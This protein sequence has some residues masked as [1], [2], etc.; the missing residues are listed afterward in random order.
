[1][2]KKARILMFAVFAA[3]LLSAVFAAGCAQ[4][5]PPAE[6]LNYDMS[7]AKWN[8]TTPFVYDGEEKSVTI[9]GLPD[10]VTVKEYENNSAVN[11]GTYTASATFD[12]DE[13]RYNTP[14]IAPCE[15]VIE[16]AEITGLS[17]ESKTVDY[18]GEKYSLTVT[19]DLPAGT[20]VRYTYNGTVADGVTEVDNY[21]VKVTVSGANYITWE[22]VAEL[23]IRQPLT[24][25]NMA[26]TVIG[27]F[28]TVPDFMSFLPEIYG[29]EN[30]LLSAPLDY[31]QPVSVTEIPVNGIGKQLHTVYNTLNYTE[32][33]MGYVSTLY[34][35]FSAIVTLYQDY[36]NRNP[37]N[38]KL[39]EGEWSGFGIRIEI[40]D[41]EYLIFA[42]AP[43]VA[44]EI[45]Q[46]TE[47]ETIYARIELFN[48]ASLKIEYDGTY[49]RTALNVVGVFTSDIKFYEDGETGN[50]T[51]ILYET[52]G[53]GSARLTTCTILTVTE[54]YLIAVGN[55]GD[56]AVPGQGVNVEVY[57][58]DTG[59]LCG[60]EV[61]ENVS[62]AD[63]GTGYDT[64]WYNLCDISGIKSISAEMG[65]SDEDNKLNK[66]TVYING[67]NTPFVPEFNS[68]AFVKTSRQYDIE[69]KT[70]Y[71]YT[72]NA[73]DENYELTEQLIPML[74]VQRENLS[75]YLEDIRGNNALSAIP[76][77]L[78]SAADNAVI[79]AAY[80]TYVPV[81]QEVKENITYE[82]TIDYIGEK[83]A[84]FSQSEEGNAAA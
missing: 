22:A 1:M 48:K 62:V 47:S 84:W 16:K 11:A 73:Q 67:Q 74:F 2:L 63:L 58:N 14:A 68:V 60:T 17:L 49:L 26:Q 57:R 10:G 31:E 28:G 4:E 9:S 61:Y 77:N 50:I 51:G 75:T 13:E 39:F 59:R 37:E 29:K 35:G 44:I 64:L 41:G 20:T 56:F 69:F 76:Q 55:K 15:W 79:A 53:I 18:D 36:I 27:A 5:D 46:A 32:Q 33:A 8:Y 66:D 34:G 71:F 54:D 82:M 43:G 6:K 25:G 83:H 42:Q 19:G 7:G 23:K 40:T 24:L 81:Y 78:S 70:M 30:H 72:Y 21:E 80:A 65:V 45:Y 52:T 3:A 12:Y 38:Y